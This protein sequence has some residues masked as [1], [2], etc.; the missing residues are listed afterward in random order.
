MKSPKPTRKPR[1]KPPVADAPDID[2][3]ARLDE[4][5]KAGNELAR[6]LANPQ[7][8]ATSTR[9]CALADWQMARD[10]LENA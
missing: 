8:F 7:S 3:T 5:I 4:V 6:L 9:I 10:N 1:R 2:V